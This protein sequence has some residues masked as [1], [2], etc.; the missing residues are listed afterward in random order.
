[1]DLVLWTNIQ[2]QVTQFLF[3]SAV[4]LTIKNVHRVS[5]ID[6]LKMTCVVVNFVKISINSWRSWLIVPSPSGCDTSIPPQLYPSLF[7]VKL[8]VLDGSK[9]KNTNRTTPYIFLCSSF[10]CPKV[11]NFPFCSFSFKGV[12]WLVLI[13]ISHQGFQKPHCQ[14]EMLGVRRAQFRCNNSVLFSWG[15]YWGRDLSVSLLWLL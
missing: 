5:W 11:S 10:M 2:W 8:M 4:K 9:R 14:C 1:M 7:P 15:N 3:L 6:L 13:T 12:E